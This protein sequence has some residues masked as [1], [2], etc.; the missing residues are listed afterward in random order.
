MYPKRRRNAV[1]FCAYHKFGRSPD[2][3]CICTSLISGFQR[4][5]HHLIGTLPDY[6]IFN[7]KKVNRGRHEIKSAHRFCIIHLQPIV[8]Y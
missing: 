6:N 2:I 5:N 3:Q 8:W 1:I 7:C 4:Y